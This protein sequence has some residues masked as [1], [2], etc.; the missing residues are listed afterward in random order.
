VARRRAAEKA[1]E[2]G[3]APLHA[4]TGS[5]LIPGLAEKAEKAEQQEAAVAAGEAKA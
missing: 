4:P 3:E 2:A 5:C 1:E